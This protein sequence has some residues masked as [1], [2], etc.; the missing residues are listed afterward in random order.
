MTDNNAQFVGSIPVAYDRYLGPLLFEPYAQDLAA[1]LR[2]ERLDAI[3]EVAAGTGILTRRLL[4]AMPRS[5]SLTVT[6]LNQPMLDFARERITDGRITWKT[7]DAQA[8][9]F[10]AGSFDVVTCQFG[11]MFV[12]DK[13]SACREARRV[14][15]PGGLFAFNAWLSP[16]ENPLGR[17][18]RD[19]TKTYFTSDPPA[20]YEVPYGLSD[21]NLVRQLLAEAGFGEVQSRVVRFQATAPSARD[22][23]RGI[24]TGTPMFLALTERATK[25]VEDIVEAVAAALAAEGG[26][27]P[28]QVPMA[29]RVYTARN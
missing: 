13:G 19:V 16:E 15:R 4:E 25:P 10:P 23:A 3:L 8:L 6:D 9:P 7:A 28:F 17:I 11:L 27:A 2:G 18:S 29:A 21:E 12:P 22:A 14:L 5:S 24:V 26:E 20:F 1:R